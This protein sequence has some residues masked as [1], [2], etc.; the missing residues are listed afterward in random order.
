VRYT[1]QGVLTWLFVLSSRS[2][3]DWDF[4][5]EE[6][7]MDLQDQDSILAPETAENIP[8]RASAPTA[9]PETAEDIP[10]LAPE[11]AEDIPDHAPAPTAEPES[12]PVPVVRTS[13][14]TIIV[15]NNLFGSVLPETVR[16]LIGQEHAQ[17]QHTSE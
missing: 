1:K 8:D 13:P 17:L 5:V 2:L 7:D 15:P 4:G 12:V 14:V 10:D 3:T 6:E 11:T 9:E 16:K